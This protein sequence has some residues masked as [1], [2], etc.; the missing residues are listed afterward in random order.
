MGAETQVH[1]V[2]LYG[3]GG[4]GLKTARGLTSDRRTEPTAHA[5]SGLLLTRDHHHVLQ[6]HFP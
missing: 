6:S 2:S 4:R 5:L 1:V 3:E